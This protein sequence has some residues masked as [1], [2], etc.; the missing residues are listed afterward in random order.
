MSSEQEADKRNSG[1]SS[2]RRRRKKR[3][4]RGIGGR[5]VPVLDRVVRATILILVVVAPLPAGGSFRWA[6]TGYTIILAML[7]AIWLLRAVVSHRFVILPS[8]FYLLGLAAI[9]VPSLQLLPLSKNL[10][11]ILSPTTARRWHEAAEIGAEIEKLTISLVPSE[12]LNYVLLGFLFLAL[13]FLIVNTFRERASVVYL[14]CAV[15]LSGLLNAVIGIVQGFGEG[16]KTYW[17]LGA[18]EWALTGTFPNKNHFALLLEMAIPVTFALGVAVTHLRDKGDRPNR[19]RLMLALGKHRE[20]GRVLAASALVFMTI[21]VLFSMSRAGTAFAL[22]GMLLMGVVLLFHRG[23]QWQVGLVAGGVLVGGILAF[24]RGMESVLSRYQDVTA[25]ANLSGRCRLDFLET[26]LDMIKDYWSCGVG[27]GAFNCTSP[28]YETVVAPDHIGYHAVNNWLELLSEIGCPAGT[29]LLVSGT[30]LLLATTLR[31]LRRHDSI[32][33][34]L[35]IGAIVALFSVLAHETLGF[36]LRKPGN[37]IVGTAT[38][39]IAVLSASIPRKNGQSNGVG[40]P[41]RLFVPRRWCRTLIALAGTAACVFFVL[42]AWPRLRG[43]IPLARLRA[44]TSASAPKSMLSPED[45]AQYRLELSEA[46]LEWTPDNPEALAQKAASLGILA[47]TA[48]DG[49]TGSEKLGVR[50]EVTKARLRDFATSPDQEGPQS[51]ASGPRDEDVAL[52]H[53]DAAVRTWERACGTV[54]TK[55]TYLAFYA[56]TRE[57]RDMYRNHVEEERI[58]RI[59]NC[60]HQ[61]Y[62]ELGRVTLL[63][64]KGAW[65]RFLRTSYRSSPAEREALRENAFRLYRLSLRQ[66]PAVARDAYRQIWSVYPDRDVL[67]KITPAVFSCHN[68]LYRFLFTHRRLDDSVEQLDLMSRL[69][70]CRTVPSDGL[71]ETAAYLVVRMTKKS[72]DQV[73][74]MIRK[75][76][77]TVLGLLRMWEEREVCVKGLEEAMERN[78]AVELEYANEL[79]AKGQV[80]RANACLHRIRT[81]VPFW[82]AAILQQASVLERMGRQDKALRVLLELLGPDVSADRAVCQEA[83]DLLESFRS[84]DMAGDGAG[85]S[86]F[87]V[88]DFVKAA[89]LVRAG[90]G[91]AAAARLGCLAKAVA[92]GIYEPWLQQPMVYYYHGMALE[93][94]SRQLEALQAYCS[95]LGVCPR[96]RPSTLCACRIWADDLRAQE[97]DTMSGDRQRVIDR[98]ALDTLCSNRT[99]MSPAVPIDV[100]FGGK[101][102]LL[103]YSVIPET[104]AP[105]DSV[106]T[107]YL[108]Q[109][110]ADLRRDYII[111]VCYYREGQ[112]VFVDSFQAQSHGSSMVHW[113][114]GEVIPLKRTFSPIRL[115]ARARTSIRPGSYDMRITLHA[116]GIKAH[117]LESPVPCYGPAFQVTASETRSE[118]N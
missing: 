1:G 93:Q 42:L 22:G 107:E 111:S 80:H 37:L 110:S 112:R 3:S 102:R 77:I 63:C 51:S 56:R 90:R 96:H 87:P 28:R 62:P 69:N 73:K 65:R 16:E 52:R 85:R 71:R 57:Y 109:C 31:I 49:M 36:G 98:Q 54:P 88:R 84:V 53:L 38:L 89:L 92:D 29:V 118:Q 97:I 17:Y 18:P 26:T 91:G 100:A 101:V 46:V 106:T 33:R 94:Q 83:Y 60:A 115:A 25:G 12:T 86:L 78:S 9:L 30:V 58:H 34:W 75:E 74:L 39:G 104:I 103:G 10:L 41:Y 68:Q 79:A 61:A 14:A 114:I 99:G 76:R 47:T 21:A 64:A 4:S 50:S 11:R 32:A 20:W 15:A 116:K 24:Q 72:R 8:G 117:R 2:R 40:K 48:V 19:N 81:V 113:R 82:P 35:G 55:G 13:F 27:M 6:W 5:L 67:K 7:V 108:W 70:T 105:G 95:A 66:T 59:Y 45:E 23:K 44:R 43:G